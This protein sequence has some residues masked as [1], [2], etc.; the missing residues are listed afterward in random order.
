MT[1]S[2]LN[3]ALRNFEAV[4]ANLNKIEN[5]LSLIEAAIPKGVVF[6]NDPAYDASCRDFDHLLKALPKID[7][8]KPD[9]HLFDLNQIARN[10]FDAQELGE[11]DYFVQVESD[12]EEPRRLLAEYRHRFTRKRRELIRDALVELI[13][14]V[15]SN[16]RE[17][18][19]PHGHDEA[20]VLV[21]HPLFEELKSNIAQINTLLGS[22]VSKPERWTDLHRHLHFGMRGDLHDIIKHDWPSVKSGLRQ[23]LY[24]E[25][26]PIPCAVEDLGVLVNKRPSGPVATKLEWT[27]L[28]EE[29]F[30]RLMFTLISSEPGYENPEWLMKTNAPDRG[31]DLSA[32]R[33]YTDPLGGTLRKRVIIQC[34]H[35]QSKSVGP[36]EIA[37]LKEQMKLW[38]PPRIDVHVIATS[39]RFTSDAV[40]LVE[41]QNQS[42]SALRIEMWPESHLERLLASRPAII[43]QFDLR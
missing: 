25:N 15:D 13:D 7:G 6:G 27:R 35:W 34:K 43:A 37:T 31:R 26:E 39:G 30:E 16:L 8:W 14:A 5:V 1:D 3:A 36:G 23:A 18:G 24:G 17:L 21:V 2:P 9:I 38:E 42:D 29:Q 10:R 28:D 41:K 33:V 12:I 4:E 20:S 40:A 32:Y 11:V 19:K 22:S